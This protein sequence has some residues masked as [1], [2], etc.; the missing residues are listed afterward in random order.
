[1]V[2]EK[3]RGGRAPLVRLE[4]MVPDRYENLNSKVRES[5]NNILR[6]FRGIARRGGSCRMDHYVEQCVGSTQEKEPSWAGCP[7][8][9]KL[10]SNVVAPTGGGHKVVCFTPSSLC[11]RNPTQGFHGRHLG[12]QPWW[13]QWLMPEGG[14]LFD[15]LPHSPFS[16]DLACSWPVTRRGW[17][18]TAL[19]GEGQVG[20]FYGMTDHSCQ[21]PP[22]LSL[23]DWE[24]GGQ[25]SLDSWAFGSM[26]DSYGNQLVR[27]R[28]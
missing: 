27:F 6:V 25:S 7:T 22:S 13:W 28:M 21:S 4:C 10:F 20:T 18:V 11:R 17:K 24:A 3:C 2:G 8:S 1:M 14:D 15:D 23:V 12:P 26:T 5:E 9:T 19:N 16:C